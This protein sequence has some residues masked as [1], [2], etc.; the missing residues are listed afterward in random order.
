[1]SAAGASHPPCPRVPLRY[2]LHWLATVLSY[3]T[4]WYFRAEGGGAA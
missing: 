2:C 1:M 3:T 4:V